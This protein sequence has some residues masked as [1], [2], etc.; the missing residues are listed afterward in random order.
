ME[1]KNLLT[2]V[3]GRWKVWN[4]EMAQIYVLVYILG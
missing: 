3:K 2:K 1:G 4:V